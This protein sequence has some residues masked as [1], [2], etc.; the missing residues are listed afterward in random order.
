MTV[1]E[2]TDWSA[3]ATTVAKYRALGCHIN[4]VDQSTT[5]YNKV[6]SLM[7]D[8]DRYLHILYSRQRITRISIQSKSGIFPG[9]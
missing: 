5:E 8:T 6:I 2:A 1:S 3:S 4:L 7:A 9:P